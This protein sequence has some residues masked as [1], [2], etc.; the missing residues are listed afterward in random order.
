[1]FSIV[2]GSLMYVRVGVTNGCWRYVYMPLM[3][4]GLNPS[5]MPRRVISPDEKNLV[6]KEIFF[7]LRPVS[8]SVLFH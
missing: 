6:A 3:L 4:V 1:M 7:M 8:L 2:S 5:G